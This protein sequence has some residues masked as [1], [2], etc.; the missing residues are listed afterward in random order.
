MFRPRIAG[1]VSVV[2]YAAVMGVSA[3]TA[4]EATTVTLEPSQDTSIYSEDGGLSNGAGPFLFSGG[5]GPKGGGADR[6]ALLAFDI[7]VVVP[8]GATVTDV[9]LFLTANRTVGG[10]VPFAL[11]R[12]LGEWGEG[13]SDSGTPGGLGA[14]AAANDATWSHRLYDTETWRNV[15]GDF[16]PEVSAETNVT[17]VGGYAWSSEGLVDDVQRWL[18]DPASNFGWI[19]IGEEEALRV[20]KRFGSREGDESDR[21]TLRV[22]YIVGAQSDAE[23]GAKSEETPTPTPTPTAASSPTTPPPTGDVEIPGIVLLALAT[24]GAGLVVGGIAMASTGRDLG[25]RTVHL[26]SIVANK[27]S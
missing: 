3:V 26:A 18:E 20:A 7:A 1:L 6:R 8:E 9:E 24:L 5:T 25:A 15:G 21:P 12:V 17:G 4:Q 14:E 2:L 10:S 16:E 19:L 13:S 22:T 23:E 27:S 11:H